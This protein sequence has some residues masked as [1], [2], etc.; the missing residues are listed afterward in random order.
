MESEIDGELSPREKA[1]LLFYRTPGGS[2]MA[3]Q[4][5]L[6]VQ[7]AIGSLCFLLAA[8][9]MKQPLYAIGTYVTFILW[10]MV[11]L[12]GA[13]RLSGVMPSIIEKYESKIRE[14]RESGAGSE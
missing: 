8:I 9:I 14:L 7:Y 2:D 1:V 11:R 13:K 12:M 4:V 3:R 6:S 10:M 5:R